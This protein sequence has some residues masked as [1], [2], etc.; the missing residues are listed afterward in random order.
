[1][2]EAQSAAKPERA[3]MATLDQVSA[4]GVAFRHAGDGHE[5][6]SHE[7]DRIE[8]VIISV[9]SPARWQLPKGIVDPGETP[10]VTALR[11]VR[12]ETGIET[13]LV[14]PLEPVEYWYVGHR[15]KQRVRFHKLVHFFLMAYESGQV[16]DH[17]HEVNEARWVSL[18]EAQTLLAFKGERQAVAQATSLLAQMEAP[19]DEGRQPVIPTQEE[20]PSG[21]GGEEGDS[22][23]SEE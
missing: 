4:G 19:S 21:L 18:E 23:R 9:G 16:S 10:E 2:S 12:E 13:T 6:D 14:A 5:A 3:K 22:E 15:G 1:M 20:S 8:I 17:D 11:E 7:A